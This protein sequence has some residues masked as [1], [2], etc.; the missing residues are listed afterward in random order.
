MAPNALV[1]CIAINKPPAISAKATNGISHLM[2][3]NT[4]KYFFVLR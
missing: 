1:L 2:V 4:P 3:P